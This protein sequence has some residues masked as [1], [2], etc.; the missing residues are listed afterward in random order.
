MKVILREDVPE[1]GTVGQTVDVKDGYGRNF[2]IPRNLAIPATRASLKAIEEIEK[3]KQ[4]VIIVEVI[5]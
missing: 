1:V 3:Q 5:E 2:L 4:K